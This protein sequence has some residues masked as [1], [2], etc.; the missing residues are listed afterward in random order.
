[1]QFVSNLNEI[2]QI[3]RICE[4]MDLNPDLRQEHF[5]RFNDF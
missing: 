1:M 5:L 3:G 2:L 4:K